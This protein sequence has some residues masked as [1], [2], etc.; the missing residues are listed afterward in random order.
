MTL[1]DAPVF[2]AARERRNHN[3]L[4][5]G[6]GLLVVLFIGGWLVSG[7]PV[8]WPW[9]WWT[10]F[11]GRTT[12]NH[13]L[14]AVE[15]NDLPKAYGI[16]FDDASWQQ[17]PNNHGAYPFDRFQ[18]DWSS[19]SSANEYGAIKSHKILAARMSGNVLLM[20][21]RINDLQS[22]NLFIDYDPNTHALG[23]S[24]VELYLGP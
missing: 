7:M 12:V 3:L 1:L 22:K 9:R 5:G 6:A 8:D 13:F 24:P 10:H 20:G 14:T 2:D 15:Q 17:H 18:Q 16:W 19:T 23:F 21:I 4:V 11:R